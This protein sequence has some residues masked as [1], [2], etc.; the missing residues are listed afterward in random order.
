LQEFL[1]VLQRHGYSTLA[2]GQDTLC[3][4]AGAWRS[5]VSRWLLG[6]NGSLSPT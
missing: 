6:L 2:L 4:R 3:L 5:G 1:G